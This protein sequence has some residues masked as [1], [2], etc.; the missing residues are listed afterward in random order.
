M[1]IWFSRA[2]EKI[3][4]HFFSRFFE[5][6]TLVNDCLRYF[7]GLH[8]FFISELMW[9]AMNLI[10][11]VYNLFFLFEPPHNWSL[12]LWLVVLSSRW[13]QKYGFCRR[14]CNFTI[15][16]VQLQLHSST[17]RWSALQWKWKWKWVNVHCSQGKSTGNST[18]WLRVVHT[19]YLLLQHSKDGL[20]QCPHSV[21]V[22]APAAAVEGWTGAVV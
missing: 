1:K 5:I 15:H 11:H 21:S 6:E 13:G 14:L 2:S 3:R 8:V 4:S 10:L 22:L 19:V 16:C 20:E 18:D 17:S 9:C 7:K 12:G